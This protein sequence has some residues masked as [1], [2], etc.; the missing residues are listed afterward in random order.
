MTSLD[1]I[2]DPICPWCYIG[3]ARLEAGIEQA[4]VNPF[5]IRWRPFQLN[6]DMPREGIS[7]EAYLSTKFGADRIT[8]LEDRIREEAAKS[9]I[10]VNY[11]K[12]THVPNTVDAHRLIGWAEAEGRQNAVVTEMFKRYFEVGADIGTRQA[13]LEIAG[14]VGMD[15]AMTER[16]LDGDADREQIIAEDSAFREMG[17]TGVPTFIVG[18]RHVVSGAQPAEL[19][20]DVVRE[21]AQSAEKSEP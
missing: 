9:G 18:G 16:L 20:A 17:V 3:K 4:S 15:V 8:A 6:P 7:R 19:W 12:A 11:T 1:I 5:T 13:L 10:E 14:A 2:S 21:L